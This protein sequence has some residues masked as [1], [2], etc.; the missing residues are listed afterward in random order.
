MS[1]NKKSIWNRL[2]GWV[3]S[4]RGQGQGRAGRGEDQAEEAAEWDLSRGLSRLGEMAVRQQ[5]VQQQSTGQRDAE[6]QQVGQ[7]L[8]AGQRRSHSRQCEHSNRCK[9]MHAHGAMLCPQ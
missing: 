4:G 6:R 3:R 7:Q 2:T 1:G 9:G 5:A 8:S